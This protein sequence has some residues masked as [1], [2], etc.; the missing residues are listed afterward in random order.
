ME[1]CVFAVLL[2][3]VYDV[4]GLQNAQQKPN[5]PFL[6][7]DNDYNM[8][9]QISKNRSSS[10]NNSTSNKFLS[11]DSG[12]KRTWAL[13]ARKWEN[14]SKRRKR[15][16]G[17]EEEDQSRHISYEGEGR[18]SRPYTSLLCARGKLKVTYTP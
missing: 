5:F 4:A 3:N 13:E 8:T 9:N 7:F 14:V 12:D 2:L 18:G 10:T 1:L 17:G 6:Y 11:K 15:R 16:S